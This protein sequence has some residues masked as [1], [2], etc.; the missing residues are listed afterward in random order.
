MERWQPSALPS[1]GSNGLGPEKAPLNRPRFRYLKQT[2]RGIPRAVLI[3]VGSNS[4]R[5]VSP[6]HPR[7]SS[8]QEAELC[9]PEQNG[10]SPRFWQQPAW[11]F[12]PEQT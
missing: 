12:G 6:S 9:G 8:S 3:S 5:G 1:E 7:T 11:T 4:P 2:A 10:T